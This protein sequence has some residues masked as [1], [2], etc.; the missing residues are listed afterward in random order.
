VTLVGVDV[1]GVQRMRELLHRTPGFAQRCF[2]ERE[3]AQCG[4]RAES[5]AGRWA[6]KEAV[7]K[8]AG[9]MGLQ[10]LPAWRAVEVLRHDGG[11]PRVVVAGWP[12]Q[13]QV[14]I[15]HDQGIAV[16]VATLPGGAMDPPGHPPIGLVLPARPDGGHKGTFGTV[17]VVAGSPGLHGAAVLAASG[18][19]RG[20]AGLVQLHVP[21]ELVSL[22]APHCVEVMVHALTG[23]RPCLSASGVEPVLAAVARH[24]GAL[25]IGCGL[26]TDDA[27]AEALGTLLQT[28]RA[29]L[30]LDADALNL[31][32]AGVAWQGDGN[33][34]MTP[35]P[36]EMAR[37]LGTS[38]AAV[39]ADRE[40]A[41]MSA[42]QRFASV[43]VLKGAHTVV[44]GPGDRLHVSPYEVVALATGGTGDVLAGITGAMLAGGLEAF[45]AAVAA[46]TVHA[47]A[48]F[49]LQLARGRA[50]VLARDLLDELPQAQERLRRALERA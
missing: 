28:V 46:V 5:W 36:A 9:Q 10:P 44:A 6:A 19:A 30:V 35:H 27:T 38:V 40:G 15:S 33:A 34:V 45:D 23:D 1:V 31:L 37:L 50:G 32:A 39:Q 7:R 26:G 29:P 8:L 47:E 24:A 17:V 14:S 20:G 49:A 16:A 42:A 2:T 3:R 18:A 48:G 41:A 11:A 25:V 43:V 4:D 21:A 22:V 13:P 12:V